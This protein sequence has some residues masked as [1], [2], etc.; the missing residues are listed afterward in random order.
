MAQRVANIL[1]NPSKWTNMSTASYQKA[2][3]FSAEKMYK[4][5]QQVF[6]N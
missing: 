1:N 2:K 6:K 4:V 3:F 5:W